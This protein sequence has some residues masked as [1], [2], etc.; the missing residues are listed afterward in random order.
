[1]YSADLAHIHHAGFG[2]LAR[3]A[4]PAI[5]RLLRG[6]G[7]RPGARVIELGCGSGILARLLND[8]GY[9]V[10]GIDASPAMIRLSRAH[11]PD[12]RFRVGSVATAR[13]PRGAAVVAVGE[14]VNYVGAR[15]VRRVFTRVH[16]ALREDGLFIFDFMA[17]ADRRAFSGK[18]FAGE[19]WALVVRADL[20]RGGRVLTRRITMFRKEAGVYRRSHETH[21][22]HVHDRDEVAAALV[23]AGFSVRMRRSYDGYRL[24]PGDFVVTAQ[25]L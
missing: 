22:I 4:A 16:G 15:T 24:L 13:L 21:R 8:A 7:V 20:D 5:I 19:D 12:A 9:D 18:S 3:G 11:A 17:S 1:M 6:H 23:G 25:K 10:L 14:V 2:D